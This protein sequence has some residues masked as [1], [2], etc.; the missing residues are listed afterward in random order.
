MAK[1]RVGRKEM[2][3]TPGEVRPREVAYVREQ[4]EVWNAL[5]AIGP[6]HPFYRLAPACSQ[7]GADED[8]L[9]YLPHDCSYVCDNCGERSSSTHLTAGRIKNR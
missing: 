9:V 3:L 6:E 5:M 8:L 4:A 2:Y 7:C 1:E